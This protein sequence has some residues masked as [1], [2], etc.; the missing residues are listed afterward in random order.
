[1]EAESKTRVQ[2]R[3]AYKKLTNTV[4]VHKAKD[5]LGLIASYTL[6]DF[7]DVPIEIWART[8]IEN[9]TNMYTATQKPVNLKHTSCSQCQRKSASSQHRNHKQ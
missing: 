1:M 8:V 4:G 6:L 5:A 2:T 9:F 7:E 3:N